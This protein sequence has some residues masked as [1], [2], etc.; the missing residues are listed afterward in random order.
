VWRTTFKHRRALLCLFKRQFV[1]LREALNI[2]KCTREII[3]CD[4]VI[5]RRDDF[6]MYIDNTHACAGGPFSCLSADARSRLK[7]SRNSP[8]PFVFPFTT[9]RLSFVSSQI[10]L[11][12]SLAILGLS[13][14]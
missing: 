6:I 2:N 11:R 14:W 3:H 9:D 12:P 4:F 13:T 8:L 7:L 1:M 5:G 10:L